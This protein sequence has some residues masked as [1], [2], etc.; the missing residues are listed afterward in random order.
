MIFRK[1]VFEDNDT[2]WE[3]ISAAIAQRKADGSEQWQD[4]YPNTTTINNDIKKGYGYVL[5]DAGKMLGYAAIIFDGEPVYEKIEGRWLT[6]GEY[7][8]VHRVAIAAEAKGRG[9]ASRI[10][11]EIENIAKANNIF[12]IKVDTNFDNMPMLHILKKM[13]YSYC[14]EVYFRGAARRAYEKI[15]V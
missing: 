6:D 3:I 2:V 11:Q 8:V 14:G 1:A 10:M 12:S 4:G 15:I 13:G 9:L 7:V 5:M